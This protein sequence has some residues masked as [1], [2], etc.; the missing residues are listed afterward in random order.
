MAEPG[1]W[2]P[3][4][5]LRLSAGLHGTACGVLALHPGWWPGLLAGLVADHAVLAAAGLWPSSQLLGPTLHHL[6]TPGDAV[7]LTFD[8]GPDPEVTPRVLDLLAAAGAKASFFCIADRARSQQ[9]LVRRIVREGH[10]VEN[11]T[12]SHPRHFAFLAG[13]A[14][15][16]EVEDGQAIL[17]DLAG[18]APRWFRAPMGLR[19][20]P[21]Y[22]VLSRAGLGLASWSRRGYDTS[23]GDPGVVLRR[24]AARTRPGD[25]LLLHDGNAAHMADGRAVVLGVLPRVLDQLRALG[26]RAVALPGATAAMAGAGGNPPSA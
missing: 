8:D 11:H 22:P 17:S 2:R 7:G 18:T 3:S 5:A 23:C 14:L 24:L 16:R 26:L 12:L 25:I 4:L 13:R 20:P 10:R 6:P 1:R 21:L 19:S 9:A 15:R